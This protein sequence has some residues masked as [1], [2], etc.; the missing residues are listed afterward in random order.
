MMTTT[1][2]SHAVELRSVDFTYEKNHDPEPLFHEFS[3]T[4]STGDVVAI[5]GSSGS[6]KSTLGRLMARMLQPNRGEIVWLT[7][8]SHPR[9]LVYVDQ[10]PFNS[11][12]PWQRVRQNLEFYPRKMRW[13]NNKIAEQTD[14]LLALFRLTHLSDALPADLSGG[15]LQRLAVA[16]CLSWKP[17]CVI[18]DE[19]FSALDGNTKEAILVALRQLVDAQKMTLILI[20]HNL[21]DALAMAHRCV[22]LGNRPV[23]VIADL[24]LALEFPRHEHSPEYL[25]A[26]TALIN[27]IRDG[28]L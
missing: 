15:E 25:Q 24:E 18:L 11:I 13:E 27:I 14:S 5:M 17:R 8:F 19:S 7:A 3:L 1:S 26:Q 22:L 2:S 10:Q 9:E 16:R 4:I 6:G 12:F 20:T 23:Q 28:I 21:S